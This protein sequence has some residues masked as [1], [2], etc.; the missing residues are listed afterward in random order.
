[1]RR[2]RYFYGWNVVAVTLVMALFSWGLG[3]Y[4]PSVYLA[5]LQRLHGWSAATVATP[6]TVYYLAGAILVSRFGVAFS[7]YGPRPVVAVGTLAMAAS[8][9][10]LGS[11]ERPWQLYPAFLVMALG[12]AAMSGAALNTLVAPWF[13]RRRGLAISLAYNGASLGGV[14]VAPALIVLIGAFGFAGAMQIA[15]GVLLAVMLP[16]TMILHRDP[17]ALGV[18]P[19]GDRMQPRGVPGRRA[20]GRTGAL[21]APRFWSVAGPFAL[22]LT[23][24]VGLI[25]HL[26]ALLVPHLG[27]GGAARAVSLATIAAI[28]GRVGTGFV[29][30][31]GNPRIA[32]TLTL[33]VQI[34]G[35]VLLARTASAGGLYVGSLLFG[36]GVGNLVTLP[37][38]ILQR[39]WAR[40]EF[41][42]LIS[43]T[44]AISQFTFAFGPA[45]IGIV[46]DWS[47]GYAAALFGCAALEA[48]AGIWVLFGPRRSAREQA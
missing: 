13:E 42:G 4:G 1:M 31:R 14:V 8:V 37:S 10:A 19:D 18:G 9:A 30:D 41:A 6:V 47:G 29:I 17:S 46:R 26:V 24:Q 38:L 48:I 34:V 28:A 15:A 33:A 20:A 32:T 25:T 43:L 7:R 36:L 23:A 35:V 27:T 3:F 5:T 2:P 39:E 11:V 12:W 22:A 16:L 40:E 21:R 44:L 45:A